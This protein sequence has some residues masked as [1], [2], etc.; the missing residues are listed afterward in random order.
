MSATGRRTLR[1]GGPP[2]VSKDNASSRNTP[3]VNGGSSSGSGGGGSDNNSVQNDAKS[4]KMNANNSRKRRDGSSLP[5]NTMPAAKIAN[6]ESE[7]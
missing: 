5:L 6:N 2:S 7:R 4:D 1:T 3:N